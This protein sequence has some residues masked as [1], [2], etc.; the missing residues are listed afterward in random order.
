[1]AKGSKLN[2]GVS[3]RGHK[4]KNPNR[5]FFFFPQNKTH[6]LFAICSKNH[7][8]SLPSNCE[9]LVQ[10]VIALADGEEPN[11]DENVQYGFKR[12]R[13]IIKRVQGKGKLKLGK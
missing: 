5:M 12:R 6:S 10:E 11:V 7:R 8:L 9:E 13:K 4:S 1:M 3:R 2:N